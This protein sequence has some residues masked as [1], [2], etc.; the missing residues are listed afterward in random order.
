VAHVRAVEASD[1]DAIAALM[2]RR[3]AASGRAW[4]ER[5]A[6]QVDANPWAAGHAPGSILVEGQRIVGYHFYVA[7]PLRA[8]D[9]PC[10]GH[11][12]FDL[13]VEPDFRGALSSIAL[14]KATAPGGDAV[15]A[16]STANESSVA[17]W[18]RL[19]AK[20]QAG[21][22]IALVRPLRPLPLLLAAAE[23]ALRGRP[24]AALPVPWRAGRDDLADIELRDGWSG[25]ALTERPDDAA[26]LWA[27][28]RRDFPL[29][30]E[31]DAAY[32]RWRY[33]AAAPGGTLVGLFDG[34]GALR[35]WYA[36]RLSERGAAMRV[37]V[38]RILD[39]VAAAGDRE[40]IAACA[41]DMRLRV[42]GRADIIE[43]RGMHAR[44]RDALRAVGFRPR[45]LASNPFLVVSKARRRRA[46]PP[47]TDWH[48]VPADGDA[49]FA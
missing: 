21:G 46:L 11:F 18:Q 30:T 36:Y 2:E 26:A 31:R 15:M 47:E 19:G 7:Q 25:R 28:V 40:A 13:Y 14:I 29:A 10:L 22:D 16:T 39:I 43:V 27:D 20:A 6:W 17:L 37:S 32:L 3:R 44:V 45:K 48:L 38:S 12:A 49:G 1:L 4:R 35:A 23:R 8:D 5:M 9:E 24:S 34:R 42:R 41:A 33:A